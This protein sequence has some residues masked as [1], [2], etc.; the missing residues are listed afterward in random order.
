MP[1]RSQVGDLDVLSDADK[2]ALDWVSKQ[3]GSARIQRLIILVAGL[4]DPKWEAD[5]LHEFMRRQAKLAC[6]CQST[7]R[8]NGGKLAQSALTGAIG[9]WPCLNIERWKS[10]NR[11]ARQ[12][13]KSSGPDAGVSVCLTVG[14]VLSTPI[15]ILDEVRQQLTGPLIHEALCQRLSTPVGRV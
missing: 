8:A 11:A 3:L 12:I 2:S 9:Y 4:S 15:E 13:L 10:A 6:A 7:I 14:T 1:G 5:D